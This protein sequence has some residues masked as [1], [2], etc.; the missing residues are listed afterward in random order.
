MT[1]GREWWG[2]GPGDGTVGTEEGREAGEKGIA[3]RGGEGDYG[4]GDWG[5]GDRGRRGAGEREG[6]EGT[7][8]RRECHS[9]RRLVGSRVSTL[10]PV[11][12]DTCS[13]RAVKTSW[14]SWVGS[15]ARNSMGLR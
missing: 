12:E 2:E 11:A 14:R 1:P 15:E 13:T 6:G 8:G 9:P 4:E 5:Q 7:G 3:E 10:S